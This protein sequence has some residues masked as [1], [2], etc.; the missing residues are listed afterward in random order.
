MKIYIGQLSSKI[1]KIPFLL[2]AVFMMNAAA[3]ALPAKVN[4]LVGDASAA[5]IT[6]APPTTY[7]QVKQTVN[8]ATAGTYRVWSRIKA[9]NT[10]AN[11][12]YFQVDT[13][14]SYNVGDAT[15]IPANAWTWVNYQD[16]AAASTISVTL[17]AGAHTLTYT[18][19]EADV[20]LDRVLL[21]SDTACVPTG[22]GDN[23]AV[24]DATPPTTAV[25]APAAGATVSGTT[26]ITASAADASGISKVDF[27]VDGAVKG[28]DTTS[29]YSYAWDT[30]TVANGAHTIQTRATDSAGNTTTSASVS[31]TVNNVVSQPDVI[32]T[33]VT[34]N[35]AAPIVGNQ[36]VY[37]AVVK[38][39]GTA[40]TPAGTTIG[41]NF[42]VDGTVVSYSSTYTSSLAPGA[43]VT[44]T[45]NNGP[46]GVNY[47]TATSGAHTILAMVDDINRFPESNETNNTLS[48]P[49]TVGQPA[50]TTAP[51]VSITAPASGTSVVAGATVNVA[52]T[53]TD[54]VGVTK[55][56]Y[57]VD[58]VLKNTDTTAPYAY[59]WA[60]TGVATGAHAITAKAY[61]AAGNTKTSTAVS[62]TVTSA[63][64]NLP[65]DVNGDSRINAIDLS[66]LISRDGQNYP[67][68]DFNNDG[69]VGSA[70][71]AILLSKWTW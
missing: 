22:T 36:V 59:G 19:K 13:G 17:T 25:T 64:T 28:T 39:Q 5:C 15:N 38:N 37:S 51:S 55:V 3:L 11:S 50:D 49:L 63:S 12:Y 32:I 6:T 16:G 70:D 68:A 9:P 31:V 62:V 24:N 27:L 18:G 21:L 47:W 8:V 61:D 26:T 23:C 1:N 10:T 41:V 7:G 71:M 48:I 69:T 58:N 44:L 66:M 20:Q 54:N 33:S 56:E 2:F 40:A 4:P 46:A 53:A 29:A 42:K 60:T 45:A 65:G 30:T 67:P 14:C 34:A 43:S 57:Y 52:A 35:P